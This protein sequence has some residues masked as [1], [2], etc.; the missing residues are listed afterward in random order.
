[1]GI[2]ING[3]TDTIQAD[4]G[5]ISIGGTVTYEDISNISFVGI[6][7]FT[8]DVLVAD[9]VVHAG[10]TNTTIRFPAADT[11]TAET[12]GSERFRITSAGNI[13]IN[14]TNINFPSGTGLQ[15][16]DASTPRLKLANSTTGVDSGS[17][18][19]LYV[20]GGDFL[21]ENKET[22]NMRFYT[23][24]T[25]VMR[26]DS[27]GRLLLGTSSTAT[28]GSAVIQGNSTGSSSYGLLR[29]TKGSTTPA[30]GDALGL[31]AF[32]D[33]NH[34]TNAQIACK[35][36]G[37]TWNSGSSH[38]TRIEFNTT[39]DG[40][41][42]SSE[43]LRI[44]SAGSFQITDPSSSTG[45][46]SKISF[47]TESPHQDEVVYIGFDRTA[48]AGGAPT[49]LTF[50]TGTVGGV[51]ERLRID[52]SGRLLVGTSSAREN[53][54]NISGISAALQV[55]G[56][57]F[58]E[59]STS[60]IRN[61]ASANAPYFILGKTRSGSVGG[62]TVVQNND[63][64]GVLS[65]QGIDGSEFV[66]GANI[67][68]EVDGTP[69]AN[70]MPGRLVF[71]TTADGASSPTERMRITSS[72]TVNIGN[73]S[74]PASANVHLDLYCN[75]SYD[76]FIRFRDQSGAP[77]LI[78]FDHGSN[79]MQFYTNG[80]SAAMLID[81]SGKLGLGTNS[82]Q[83]KLHIS[84]TSG[85]A[86]IRMT[87]SSGSSDI[88]ADANIYFQ[89]NGTTRVTIT[90]AGYLCVNRTSVVHGGQIS[91]NY[92][93]GVTA[94]IALKDTQTSGTGTP[95]Q[96]V[97]G[98][99]AVIGS[100]TQSQSAT[101]FNTSSDYRLKENVVAI[102][103]GITRVKQL[104]PKRFNF[105]IDTYTTV[106]GFLAHEAQTIVPEAV[107]GTYNEVDNDG[108]DVMQGI[109]QSKL[110]PLLTAALQE[111]IAKIETL[112]TANADLVARVITLEG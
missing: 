95:M 66:E 110:V 89:P 111:A 61:S 69:G 25:E 10:D 42:G 40:Q 105:I 93:N 28:A 8:S 75:S 39:S 106:D 81:S 32:G 45:L 49:D 18:S 50:A 47:V 7:T 70:D 37:G 1:M 73:S 99:N 101:S 109:D 59:S 27:S 98:F 87:G 84:D 36:D 19:L 90:S 30:N 107:T 96:F 20:S 55:E 13:G 56:V 31:L 92:T 79:A 34:N 44:T 38:P 86:Q 80:S 26:I 2:Q 54:I 76:A 11:I 62:T 77:G 103:N 12:G 6:A 57:G 48:S 9:R 85:S 83:K 43:R 29:L 52:S 60:I 41:S 65:F 102:T 97:N 15:V 64:L 46:K 14:N 5:S 91:L 16:Y 33:S 22:A 21:I 82:P 51:S 3:L 71:S 94:G 17:G 53:F 78:G 4:D 112:E 108:N 23:S 24:A 104:Q 35:R 88:Y 63:P 67:K 74:T 68:A 100:I 58:N 72:G